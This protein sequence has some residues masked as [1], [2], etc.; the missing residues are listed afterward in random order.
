MY[1]IMLVKS[2]NWYVFIMIILPLLNAILK[3]CC[4]LESESMFYRDNYLVIS[5][6]DQS[7]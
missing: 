2:R 1:V 4:N 7:K 5:A 3:F 6:H